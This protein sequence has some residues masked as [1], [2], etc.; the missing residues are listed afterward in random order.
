MSDTQ[1]PR[2]ALSY[3]VFSD[4]WLKYYIYCLG[5]SAD[6]VGD[7]KIFFNDIYTIW[8]NP[9]KLS[10][11]LKDKSLP[12]FDH[13]RYIDMLNSDKKYDNKHSKFCTKPSCTS[14]T[15]AHSLEQ[16]RIPD[17]P[18]K[19]FCNAVAIGINSEYAGC[20]GYCEKNHGFTK[21]EY[22]TF[23]DIQLPKKTLC[24]RMT[25]DQ[26]CN[27]PYC[28]FAHSI[29]DLEPS[30]IEKNKFELWMLRSSDMNNSK[31]LAQLC[32]EEAKKWNEAYSEEIRG[33]EEHGWPESEKMEIDEVFD[34]EI[35]LNG[36]KT[37]SL[38]GLTCL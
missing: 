22:L 32:N 30:F 15:Y 3:A 28:T 18:Y 29:W 4:A 19:E 20:C 5:A 21:E 17:C 34:T 36:K 6:I 25:K 13:K 10:N 16:L 11:F 27:V 2:D 14:C 23:Y 7:R 31:R 12:P 24:N 35:T 9:E 8:K 1:N 33:Y 37:L 26:P 38:S